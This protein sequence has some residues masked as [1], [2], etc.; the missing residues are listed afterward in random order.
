MI[1]WIVKF[2]PQLKGLAAAPNADPGS[3]TFTSSRIRGFVAG[4]RPGRL[5]FNDIDE[6][7]G[8]ERQ[9]RR[10][11]QRWELGGGDRAPGR[12]GRVVD[13]RGG[14]NCRGVRCGRGKMD[15]WGDDGQQ[16]PITAR[17]R[18][19][20]SSRPG[21]LCGTVALI[22]EPSEETSG[23]GLGEVRGRDLWKRSG[24]AR[25]VRKRSPQRQA[26][27]ARGYRH[28]GWGRLLAALDQF[29]PPGRV[30]CAGGMRPIPSVRIPSCARGSRASAKR[31][32][33]TTV[34][35]DRPAG[36]DRRRADWC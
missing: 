10:S 30:R 22:F 23:G 1:N 20:P 16:P 28:A 14:T 32:R 24:I 8:D 35:A 29:R 3:S 5:V 33:V 27:S 7:N 21:D 12:H 25:C 31:L 18:R 19:A 15:A 36:R 26:L 2:E 4:R 9:D 13:G 6:G 34:A 17:G 11:N